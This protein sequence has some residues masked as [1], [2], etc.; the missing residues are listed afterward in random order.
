[1][2]GASG[3]LRRVPEGE[4]YD[5]VFLSID[6]SEGPQFTIRRAIDGGNVEV[7]EFGE[8][9]NEP[10]TNTFELA[11]KHAPGA[12]RSLSAY[13]LDRIGLGARQIRKNDRGEKV[14]LSFRHV[15]DLT[16]ISEERIIHQGSPVLSGQYTE[17]TREENLFAFFL[18]GQD[19]SQIIAQENRQKRN[20]RLDAELGVVESILAERR[21]GLAT[22]VGPTDLADQISRL[23]KTIDESSS[24]VVRTQEEISSLESERNDLVNERITKTSRFGFLDEQMQRFRLLDDYYETDVERLQAVLEAS[25]IFHEL[26]EGMCPLCNQPLVNSEGGHQLQHADFEAACAREIAKIAVLRADL[27]R[28]IADCKSQSD[29]LRPRLE[30][31][32][33]RL[34]AIETQFRQTLLPSVRTAQ[35]E[36]QSAIQLRT[37]L[38]QAESLKATIESLEERLTAIQ[39]QRK[40]KLPKL[41]FDNRASTSAAFEFCKVVEELLKA[42]KYPR[43]GTVAF[44]SDKCDLVIGGQDRGNKGKGYR[45]VTYAAFAIGLM[46]YCRSKGIPHPGFVILDTPLNPFKGPKSAT[47]DDK[48]T[49]EVKVAFYEYLANDTSGDQVI[50]L[51][52]EEPPED[53]RNRIAYY[54]FTANSAL[55]RFGFFP[56]KAGNDLTDG[57]GAEPGP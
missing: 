39:Q 43:L 31:V 50:I 49:N 30:E 56:P 41:E 36:L 34:Q 55:G 53:V 40:A 38:A 29:T 33:G 9:R 24:S 54:S 5:R 32:A 25:R 51:E 27:G 22:L 4:G 46:K 15:S 6:A 2:L 11:A 44:D 8:G 42:W 35:A 7:Q 17:G 23:E 1:M 16:F 14:A 19:D 26:P 18:T 47:P 48:L 21:V 20:A 3:P 10:P 13:L 37:T 28:A 57:N 45:A 12:D 52:N